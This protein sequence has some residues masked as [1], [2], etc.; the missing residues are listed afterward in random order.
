M[1]MFISN[2]PNQ[3]EIIDEG[4]CGI[5]SLGYIL[6]LYEVYLTLH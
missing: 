4:V 6:P 2:K 5:G 3:M 1:T